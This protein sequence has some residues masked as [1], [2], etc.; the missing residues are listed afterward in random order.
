MTIVFQLD[1]MSISLPTSGYSLQHTC[2][3]PP[4]CMILLPDF[5]L[6][7]QGLTVRVFKS[8]EARWP[9]EP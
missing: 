8:C 9:P 3:R 2:L 4:S 6:L 1:Q 7:F 5:A